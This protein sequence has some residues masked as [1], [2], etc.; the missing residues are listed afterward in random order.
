MGRRGRRIRIGLGL[1]AA[2]LAAL[3]AAGSAH[4]SCTFSGGELAVGF[5]APPPSHRGIAQV[6]VYRNDQPMLSEDVRVRIDNVGAACP[7]APTVNNTDLI[8]IADPAAGRV[9][10]LSLGN[11]S[12][13]MV[14]LL[15]PGLTDEGDGSSEI[16]ISASLGG[17]EGDSAEL[18]FGTSPDGRSFVQGDDKILVGQRGRRILVNTNAG[19]E[20]RATRDADISIAGLGFVNGSRRDGGLDGRTVNG[21]LTIYA[22]FGSDLVKA[23]GGG[24]LGGKV[25]APLDV[26]LTPGDGEKAVLG[27]GSDHLVGSQGPDNL[28]TKG[29][30]DYVRGDDGRD[31]INPGKGRDLVEG[32][33]G[34]D[35]FK[36]RDGERDV[37]DCGPGRDKV[38]ADRKDKIDKSCEKVRRRR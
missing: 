20:P 21:N 16:E 23:R 10:R 14:T 34:G 5:E 38:K 8:T 31:K 32:G 9:S 4:A 19:V 29:G 26:N 24:D 17:D 13:S 11:F 35:R 7:G 25:R 28:K 33:P 15:E 22:G 18:D 6:N 30:R 37:V 3:T 12:G 2:A 27:E 1:V 36:V